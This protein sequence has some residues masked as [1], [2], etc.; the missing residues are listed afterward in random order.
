M[1]HLLFLPLNSKLRCSP[2]TYPS[3]S[4]F[5]FF[6]IILKSL[7]P[8]SGVFPTAENSL[9]SLTPT[10][11]ADQKL[12][13]AIIA[14][15]SISVDHAAVAARLGPHCTAR[16]VVERLK[17]LRK[18]AVSEPADEDGAAEVAPVKT[19]G[20]GKGSKIV[21]RGETSGNAGPIA[22]EM[23]KAKKDGKEFVIRQDTDEE[24]SVFGRATQGTKRKRTDGDQDM[25]AADEDGNLNF[26][27]ANFENEAEPDALGGQLDGAFDI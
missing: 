12:F 8:L 18:L 25:E 19:K 11:L 4:I 1:V 20:K 14:E 17:K 6:P 5:S 22:Q 10:A 16:A 9:I 7:L 21:K 3:V 23:K 2:F 15:H 26:E 24:G 13:M 27:A